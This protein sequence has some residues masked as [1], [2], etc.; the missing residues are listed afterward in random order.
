MRKSAASRVLSLLPYEGKPR[1]VPNARNKIAAL[2]LMA[3]IPDEAVA[4]TFFDPQ[5]RGIMD[6]MAYG[7]EGARQKARAK[8]PQMTD[9]DI[10]QCVQRI[11]RLLKPSGHLVLW[12]DKFT[13]GSGHHIRYFHRAKQLALV[14][15]QHWNK[16]R[17]GMGKRT[18]GVS[19][20]AVILQKLPT[21]AK[22]IWM[23]HRIPDSW[24]EYADQT[25]HPHCKPVQWTER[26]I[27][28]VTKRGDLVLDPCAGGYGVLEAC[29]VSKREFIG[30]DVL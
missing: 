20:Y 19:E 8:L 17:F 25:I 10:A 9:D 1:I 18:R 23:D 29:R 11:A 4:L 27:R 28:A 30:G 15:L 6:K 22:G 26:I 14:D 21:R 13:I 2:E 24:T 3:A 5:Y 16:L 12:V 7:N